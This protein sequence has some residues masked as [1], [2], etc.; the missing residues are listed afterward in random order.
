MHWD[1]LEL[2]RA[3]HNSLLDHIG[4]HEQDGFGIILEKW[5]ARDLLYEKEMEWLTSEGKVIRGWGMGPDADGQLQARDREG[6]IHKILS[7]DV[8]L[9]Q[10][11]E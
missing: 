7:G 5:R 10:K 3:I 2:Y 11:M 9:Y 8:Q 6:V 1:I 4:I